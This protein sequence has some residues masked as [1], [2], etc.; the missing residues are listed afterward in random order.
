MCYRGRWSGG[1]LSWPFDF[2]LSLYHKR[3]P[4]VPQLKNKFWDRVDEIFLLD[5]VFEWELNLITLRFHSTFF[6][7]HFVSYLSFY[8]GSLMFML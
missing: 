1:S 8:A 4:C 7:L 6:Y 3:S 2:S 5:L